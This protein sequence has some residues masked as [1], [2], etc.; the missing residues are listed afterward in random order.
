METTFVLY[1]SWYKMQ[2]TNSG[3]MARNTDIK[4]TFN[5]S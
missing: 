2:N 3:K 1:T 5:N 4:Q